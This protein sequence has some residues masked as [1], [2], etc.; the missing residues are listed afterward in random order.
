[1]AA[2]KKTNKELNE[3]LEKLSGKYEVLKTMLDAITTKVNSLDSGEENIRILEIKIDKI[4]AKVQEMTVNNC[5]SGIERE[6]SLTDSEVCEKS[7]QSTKNLKKHHIGSSGV[8]CK[9]CGNS[10]A[11]NSDLE[12]NIKNIHKEAEIYDCDK[13]DKKFLLKWRLKKHIDIHSDRENLRFCHYFNNG[14]V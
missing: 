5:E 1:M 12:L 11:K 4:D 3:E 10:F 7:T 9:V 6:N 13:C 14:K 8:K 2:K